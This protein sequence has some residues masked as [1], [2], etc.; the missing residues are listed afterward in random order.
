LEQIQG[1][2]GSH[3]A[4]DRRDTEEMLELQ[5][6]LFQANMNGIPDAHQNKYPSTAVESTE[7]P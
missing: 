4:Q 3:S 6:H 5:V 1:K 7:F 2:N